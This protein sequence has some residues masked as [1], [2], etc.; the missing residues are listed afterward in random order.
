MNRPTHRPIA[1]ML[2]AALALAALGIGGIAVLARC[3]R[4]SR[5]TADAA[6]TA[7]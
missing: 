1:W 2:P 3:R 6:L 7:P 5:Q 4:R